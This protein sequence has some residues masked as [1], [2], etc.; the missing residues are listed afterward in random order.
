MFQD[1][2]RNECAARVFAV[3]FAR[4][5][6]GTTHPKTQGGL[7]GTRKKILLAVPLRQDK[8]LAIKKKIFLLIFFFNLLKKRL[9]SVGGGVRP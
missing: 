4:S 8:G 6:Y 5:R 1:D 7:K 3:R 9:S 2:G